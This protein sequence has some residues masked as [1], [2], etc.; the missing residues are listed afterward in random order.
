MK[1]YLIALILCLFASNAYAAITEDDAK[2]ISTVILSMFEAVQ[3]GDS[4][5]A[6][7]LQTEENRKM[8]KDADE[9]GKMLKECCDALHDTV[10]VGFGG[11]QEMGAQMSVFVAMVDKI[12]NRWLAQFVME[13]HEH[14]QIDGIH[15]KVIEES[16]RKEMKT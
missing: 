16:K 9:F 5:T 7:S 2:E 11:A 10:K 13:K 6:L 4:A 15:I 1:K 12:G 14:W 3:K 8:F